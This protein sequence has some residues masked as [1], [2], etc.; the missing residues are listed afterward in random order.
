MHSYSLFG[1]LVSALVLGCSSV[2]LAATAEAPTNMPGSSCKTLGATQISDD[3]T[4]IIGC[5][6]VTGTTGDAPACTNAKGDANG[7]CVWKST[8]GGGFGNCYPVTADYAAGH[9]PFCSVKG[10]FSDSTSPAAVA[11]CRGYANLGSFSTGLA[12]IVKS[13]GYISAAYYKTDSGYTLSNYIGYGLYCNE[14][15]KLVSCAGAALSE[16]Y[17]CNGDSGGCE[18]HETAGAFPSKNGCF[19]NPGVTWSTNNSAKISAICCKG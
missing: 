13:F 3:K 6:L 2:S 4:G 16:G 12:N 5:F 11:T 18:W 15:Y 19:T 7:K 17:I 9:S 14:G 1:L 10:V 8:T